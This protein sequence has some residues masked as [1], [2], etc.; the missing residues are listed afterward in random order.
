MTGSAAI[1]Q[2]LGG[3]QW[4]LEHFL[5]DFTDEEFFVRPVPGAN[6]VAWQVGHLIEAEKGMVTSQIPT[7]KY[8]ELPAG[9]K[10]AH[11]A[12]RAKHDGRDSF[13]S[14]AEYLALAQKV[15]AVTMEVVGKLADADLDKP[16]TGNMAQFAPT[17]GAFLVLVS[18][19]TLMHAGQ[20]SVIRRKL[21]KPVLM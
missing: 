11:K 8:P 12:E 10:E 16:T 5:A 17:L 18:N 20:F 2:A 19:H 1:Q 3:S 7:A 9:F 4:L 14:K 21:G 15:R 6:N 13:L